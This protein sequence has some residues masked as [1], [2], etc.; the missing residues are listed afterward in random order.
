MKRGVYC[1]PPWPK[2]QPGGV[3]LSTLFHRNSLRPKKPDWH[4]I[5]QVRIVGM[6][7]N[8]DRK[9]KVP[10]ARKY[11]KSRRIFYVASKW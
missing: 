2:S 10:C 11:F 9:L 4:A 8:C 7:K 1:C 6:D 5:L 3:N